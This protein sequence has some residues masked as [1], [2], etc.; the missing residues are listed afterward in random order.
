MVCEGVEEGS[1]GGGALMLFPV[2]LFFPV[3]S[4]VFVCPDPTPL[5]LHPC[6]P[7]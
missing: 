4:R 6:R 5:C 7:I 2:P 1:G 3:L